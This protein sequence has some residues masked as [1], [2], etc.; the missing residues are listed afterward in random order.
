MLM[1][2]LPDST[3]P[4]FK[5]GANE[6]QFIEETTKLILVAD[7]PDDLKMLTDMRY[8]NCRGNS[9]RSKFQVFFEEAAVVLEQENGAGAHQR[10]HAGSDL[11]S[12]INISYAP[13][14]ISMIQLMKK[15]R[16]SL[17]RKEMI[18]GI[19][20]VSP[21]LSWLY[22]QLSPNKECNETAARYTGVIPFKRAIKSRTA[23]E[24][25]PSGHWNAAMKRGWQKDLADLFLLIL[26]YLNSDDDKREPMLDTDMAILAT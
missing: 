1:A 14:I 23:R 17:E 9:S 25:N 20:F 5:D 3:L 18:E 24:S 19:D 12:T 22:L 26:D 15:R 21:C 6:K 7:G 8:H 13:G 4:S 10:R 2:T 16:E 11:E